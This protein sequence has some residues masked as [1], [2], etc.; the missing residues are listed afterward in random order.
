MGAAQVVDVSHL[1]SSG[2][3]GIYYFRAIDFFSM[4]QCARGMTRDSR[5]G[6]RRHRSGENKPAILLLPWLLGDSAPLGAIN[7]AATRGGDEVQ[8]RL[9]TKSTLALWVYK[10]P[11][12]QK[13]TPMETHPL[14]SFFLSFVGSENPV[15]SLIGPKRLP[16]E[17]PNLGWQ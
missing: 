9:Q 10:L 13:K 17:V 5:I 8:G 2:I 7:T 12:Q 15:S 1:L 3:Y 6:P 11:F 4:S 16:Q 14:Q